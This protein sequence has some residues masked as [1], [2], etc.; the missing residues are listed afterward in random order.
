MLLRSPG[1]EA[2][3][4]SA[5]EVG[6]RHLGSPAAEVSLGAGLMADTARLRAILG[7]YRGVALIGLMDDFTHILLEESVRDLRG[8]ILCRGRHRGLPDSAVASRHAFATTVRTRGVGAALAGAPAHDSRNLLVQ[9]HCSDGSQGAGYGSRSTGRSVR[10]GW[11]ASWGEALG[12]ALARMALGLWI[13]GPVVAR[14]GGDTSTLHP[15][16]RAFVSLVAQL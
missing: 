3:A 14:L 15:Q 10:I 13:P 11:A 1:D 7:S 9:E 8:S 6:R 4:L 5:A 12:A 2:F 16:S